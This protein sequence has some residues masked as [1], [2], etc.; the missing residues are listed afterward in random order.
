MLSLDR[1][2]GKFR[3]DQELSLGI[4]C[5]STNC[6]LLLTK[7][8]LSPSKILIRYPLRAFLAQV[9]RP[10]HS[11][12]RRLKYVKGESL[13]VIV[14]GHHGQ[15]EIEQVAWK[16]ISM[17]VDTA[18]SQILPHSFVNPRIHVKGV[19][20][21]VA[22]MCVTHYSHHFS[23][24][25]DNSLKEPEKLDRPLP[26]NLLEQARRYTLEMGEKSKI[27]KSLARPCRVRHSR[28]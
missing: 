2:A 19:K 18:A 12:I 23:D 11:S 25:P 7:N 22:K 14:N 13:E 21:K 20:A 9:P 5:C 10:L 16:T 24:S 26:E 4:V 3:R 1:R 28:H 17:F 15:D 27:T 8:R 6:F